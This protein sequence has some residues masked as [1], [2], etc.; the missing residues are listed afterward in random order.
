MSAD[1]ARAAVSPL[2]HP[3]DEFYALRGLPLPDVT[4]IPGEEVPEPERSLLVHPNDM[5]ST[6]MQFHGDGIH[7]ELL[8]REL[9]G[10]CYLR[11]VVLRLNAT[12]RPVEF[13]AIKIYLHLLPA[14]ARRWILEETLPLGQILKDCQVQFTSRPKAYLRVRSDTFI[15]TSL[16][17]SESHILYGRRNT[18]LDPEQRPIA[19]IVEILPP[20]HPKAADTPGTVIGQKPQPPR[21]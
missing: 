7:L 20:C 8:R 11:E 15:Q 4:A 13:G 5:T 18:L 6:L 19:E 21:L 1:S 12:Q 14:A 16:Q 2:L 17:L 10:E 3:M 9:R